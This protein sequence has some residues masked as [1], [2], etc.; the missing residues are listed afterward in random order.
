MASGAQTI[1][2]GG[3]HMQPYFVDRVEGPLGV[4]YEHNDPGQAVFSKEVA[5]KAVGILE[6][7]VDEGYSASQ[8]PRRR[9]ARRRKDR[10]AGRQHECVVRR[11]DTAIDHRG[12]GG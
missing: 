10:H 2:N 6:G 4:V 5:D 8:R 9:A 11:H 3:V 12:L 1:A 7:R